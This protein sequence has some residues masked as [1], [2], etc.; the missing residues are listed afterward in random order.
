[1]GKPQIEDNAQAHGCLF[2]GKKTGALGDAAGHSFYPTKNLG[3]LGDAGAVTTDDKALANCIYSLGNYGSS[4]KYVFD[5]KGRNS[6]IDEIQAAVLNVKLQYLETD[7]SR[8]KNIATHYLKQIHH[9]EIVL[10][11]VSD[12]NSHVFHIFPIRSK[13]RDALQQ[14]LSQNGIETVI[15]YP[16]PPHKQICYKEWNNL[17]LPVTEKIHQ[18]ILSLPISPILTEKEVA[19]ISEAVNKFG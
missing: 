1:M 14:H 15:H 16:I 4:K 13:K 18:E 2:N 5:Y 17:S 9:S 6:R 3:A 10:P 7:N 8:R 12:W 11:H 19:Y